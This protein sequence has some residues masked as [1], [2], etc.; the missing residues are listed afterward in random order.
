MSITTLYGISNCDTVKR[1]RA[2]MTE[3]ELRK[4]GLAPMAQ[5]IAEVDVAEIDEVARKLYAPDDYAR[6]RV[7]PP[8]YAAKVRKAESQATR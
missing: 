6:V 2:W 8:G 7:V 1:A 4:R 5:R 3:Q